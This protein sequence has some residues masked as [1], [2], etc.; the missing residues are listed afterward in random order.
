MTSS[1]A[2][3]SPAQKSAIM[4][5]APLIA[6]F[7]LGIFIYSM[8]WH[9]YFSFD[10]LAANRKMI[11]GLVADHFALSVLGFALAY[12]AVTSLSLPVGSFF[13]I[14]G[15]FLFGPLVGGTATVVGATIGALLIF[16]IVRTSLGE[17]LAARAGPFMEKLR[18][19]FKENALSYMF[20]LRLAP[21]FPFWLVNIAPALLG[22]KTMT[23]FIG[24]FFGIMPATYTFSYIGA[25]L[26]S[27]IDA[28]G[29]AF[30]ACM[31]KAVSN[32]VAPSCTVSFNPSDL[33][34]PELLIAFAG[35]A[36]IALLPVILNKF[37]KS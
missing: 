4:R 11:T 14:L 7:G 33:V 19:G 2:E 3:N 36:I 34:T 12:A 22:V 28:Q 37:R 21:V 32:G 24:T 30:D 25:G 9:R 13:T 5:F 17:A 31:A 6:I 29:H 26:G 18:D 27:V 16:F 10:Q 1:E 8:G 15:G 23:Y 20:F 35:L